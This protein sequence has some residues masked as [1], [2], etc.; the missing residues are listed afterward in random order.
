MASP[1]GAWRELV[2]PESYV[3]PEG[4]L[5]GVE[6]SLRTRIFQHEQ[7]GDDTPVL[8]SVNVGWVIRW[9]GRGLAETRHSTG[10]TGAYNWDAPVKTEADLDKLC[11]RAV[12]VDRAATQANQELVQDILGDILEVRRRGAMFWTAGLT[13]TLIMLRGLEQVMVDIYDNPRLLHRLMAYLRDDMLGAMDAIEREGVLSLNNG[14]DDY[15]GSGGL[16]MTDELPAAGF[17]GTV[18]WGDL[19]GLG[20]SQEFVGVGPEHF[21]EFALQ[22]QLPL[23]RRFGLVCYGCCEGLDRKFDLILGNIPNLRRVSVSPWCDRQVA[24]EKLGDRYIYSWKPNPTVICRPDP[25][26]REVEE[27]TAQTLRMARGCRIEMVMKDTHTVHGDTSRFRKWVEISRR[28]IE[29]D[30]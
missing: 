15:V 25:D 24:A 9:G 29:R 26:W 12:E 20:E 2:P 11:F 21:D 23:L 13:Q 16:G 10:H 17:A 28:C 30:G 19:W 6:W 18:R 1:E 27:L 7:I 5:R 4:F 8:P 14:P 3:C 22:Y